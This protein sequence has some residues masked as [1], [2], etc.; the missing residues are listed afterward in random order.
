MTP[1]EAYLIDQFPKSQWHHIPTQLRLAYAAADSLIEDSPI[2]R[3]ESAIPNRGRI[4]SWATD[5]QL[6]R[7][8]KS[9]VLDCDYQWKSF[10]HPTG[11]YLEL[12]FSH[13]TASISFVKSAKTQPRE[14]VFRQNARL[15][16]EPFLPLDDFTEETIITGLPHF[17]LLHG[18][19]NL[20]FAHFALPSA[21]SN[22]KL[23]WRSQNLL[24]LPHEIVSDT[25]QAEDTDYDLDEILQLKEELT[26]WMK[27]NDSR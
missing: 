4:I 25:H 23:T 15:N 8:I 3:V 6:E 5:L 13:L 18:H 10:A 11:K 20:E 27:D 2:L 17:L 14:V 24:S 21:H 26:K 22:K 12:R 19:T 16:N 7:A 1:P 9:G